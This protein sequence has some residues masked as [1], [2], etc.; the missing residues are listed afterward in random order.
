MD[1]QS[2]RKLDKINNELY[3]LKHDNKNLLNNQKNVIYPEGKALYVITK[4]HNNK[5]Y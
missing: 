4:I 3:E 5:K 2:K 1:T